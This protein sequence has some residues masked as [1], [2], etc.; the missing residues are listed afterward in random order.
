MAYFEAYVESQ[1][2]P[3]FL[4][5]IVQCSIVAEGVIQETFYGQSQIVSLEFELAHSLGAVTRMIETTINE[6]NHHPV[7]S[8][9]FCH[10][11]WVSIAQR[12]SAMT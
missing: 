11:G 7:T 6:R 1:L 2:S 3:I 10:R 4:Q 9:S 5:L 12:V 8:S